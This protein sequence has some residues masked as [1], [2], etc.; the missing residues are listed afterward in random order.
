M[1]NGNHYVLPYES[2]GSLYNKTVLGL[3]DKDGNEIGS[4]SDVDVVRIFDIGTT[5]CFSISR[6][7]GLIGAYRVTIKFSKVTV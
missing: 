7:A 6:G 5:R 4:P 2:V 3:Y 1:S